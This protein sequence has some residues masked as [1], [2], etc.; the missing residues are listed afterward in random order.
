MTWLVRSFFAISAVAGAALVGGLLLPSRSHVERAIA[1]DRPPA[2]VHTMLTSLRTFHEWSPWARREPNAI[3]AF[4]GPEF[5]PGASYLWSGETIG[6]GEL[7]LVDSEPYDHVGYTLELDGRGRA[8]MAFDIEPKPGGSVVTWGYDAAFGFDLIGRY[9]GRF[10]DSRLGPDFEAGLVNLKEEAE[11]LPG[12]DFADTGAE[13]VEVA[14]IQAVVYAD[15]VRG[16]AAD[17]QR[18]FEEALFRVRRY[19][20]ANRLRE[21]GPAVAITRR[22]EPPLWV[23]EAAVP[24]AGERREGADGEVTFDTLPSGRAVRAVHRGPAAG[25]A[26]LHTKLE[27]YLEANRLSRAGPSWEVY[28]TERDI[29]PSDD[30]VTEI[31]IP[32]E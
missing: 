15:Q 10:F 8:S 19:M 6:E 21:A 32:V 20:R 24:Y 23:F 11:K 29:A 1:I 4:E 25:V 2:T 14:P 3:F 16:D 31:Y 7:T 17:Q 22:W 5:G 18:A 13:I 26:P 27:A 30:Q 9:A 12:A 28:V